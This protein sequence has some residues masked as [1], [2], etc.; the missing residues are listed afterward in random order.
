L[1][2]RLYMLVERYKK[3]RGPISFE[4]MYELLKKHRG[5]YT[6]DAALKAWGYDAETAENV[7]VRRRISDFN[8]WA[9]REHGLIWQSTVNYRLYNADEVRDYRRKR[10]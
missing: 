10:K 5:P 3:K 9:E 7:T 6:L 1:H 2:G 8:E 4:K